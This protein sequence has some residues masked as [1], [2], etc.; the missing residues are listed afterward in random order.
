LSDITVS[1][2]SAD[3]SNRGGTAGGA[4]AGGNRLCFALHVRGV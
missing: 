1:M 2:R 4:P 3:G